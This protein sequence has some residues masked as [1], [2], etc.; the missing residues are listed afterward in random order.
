MQQVMT[1]RTALIFQSFT[2]F[3]FHK[4]HTYIFCNGLTLNVK[5]TKVPWIETGSAVTW[6]DGYLHQ[7]KIWTFSRSNSTQLRKKKF[8]G[9]IVRAICEELRLRNQHTFNWMVVIHNGIIRDF[10][11]PALKEQMWLLNIKTRMMVMM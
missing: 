10:S 3:T 1:S 8:N 4:S 7:W 9:I 2:L 11:N 5:P 6:C